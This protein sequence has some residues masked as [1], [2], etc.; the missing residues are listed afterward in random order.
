MT[1]AALDT[2]DG[3]IPYS[4]QCG[5]W[6]NV[7]LEVVLRSEVITSVVRA[8]RIADAGFP[9]APVE[10]LQ[11]CSLAILETSADKRTSRTLAV[12]RLLSGRL[13]QNG[14]EVQTVGM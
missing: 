5:R 14:G 11:D 4:P 7:R 2:L 9:R 8:M 10:R 12:T 1:Y 13:C 3:Q 6:I